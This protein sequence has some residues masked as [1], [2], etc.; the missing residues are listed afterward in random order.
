MPSK[1]EIKKNLK[2]T[3]IAI[4]KSPKV[5]VAKKATTTRN[6]VKTKLAI[7]KAVTKSD[8]SILAQPKK[9]VATKT[10]ARTLKSKEQLSAKTIPTLEQITARAHQ[11]WLDEGCPEGRAEMHWQQA[12]QELLGP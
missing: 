11:I 7:G 2:P 1:S 9:T 5:P 10:I 8:K 12:E 3:K 4:S 6:S